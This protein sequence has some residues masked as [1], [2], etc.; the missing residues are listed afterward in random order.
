MNDKVNS[1]KSKDED[2]KG[3]TNFKYTDINGTTGIINDLDIEKHAKSTDR[4]YIGIKGT[5]FLPCDD[6][7]VFSKYFKSDLAMINRY[8]FTNCNIQPREHR[9]LLKIITENYPTIYAVTG[10]QPDSETTYKSFVAGTT[11]PDINI[12]DQVIIDASTIMTNRVAVDGNSKSMDKIVS[13]IKS[14]DKKEYEDYI[15][16]NPRTTIIQYVIVR[17]ADVIGIVS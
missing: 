7:K 2:V 11:E 3:K 13:F 14:L 5:D 16:L 1:N 12:G 6:N 8:S 17:S 10:K 15:K 4:D 9:I